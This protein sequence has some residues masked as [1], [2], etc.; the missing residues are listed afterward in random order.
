MIHEL[1]DRIPIFR[2]HG[3]RLVSGTDDQY[4]IAMPVRKEF[5]QSGG[6]VHG[7]ILAT[8]AD[9]TAVF[10]LYKEG[11]E[12]KSIEFKLNFL[13]PATLDGGEIL[14]RAKCVKRGSWVALADVE[15][16]QGDRLIAK[17]LFTYLVAPPT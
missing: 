4:E 15:L 1:F 13:R 5:L 10:V 9:T 8:L 11:D 3:Y 2:E 16:F 17:G 6:V 7:G 12:M 14:A